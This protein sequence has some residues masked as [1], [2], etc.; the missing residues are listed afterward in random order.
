MNIQLTQKTTTG[1]TPT[2]V[3]CNLQ[4][5]SLKIPI[6]NTQTVRDIIFERDSL[7]IKRTDTQIR[8]VSQELD[9]RLTAV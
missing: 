2:G 1:S 5:E 4:K 6:T 3:R 8:P 9:S 7:K